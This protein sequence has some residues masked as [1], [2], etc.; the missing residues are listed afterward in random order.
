M[1]R[2]YRHG[3]RGSTYSR[4]A[5]APPLISQATALSFISPILRSIIEVPNACHI[6]LFPSVPDSGV[7]L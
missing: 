6:S 4:K 7:S 3:S 2:M 1:Y 5:S